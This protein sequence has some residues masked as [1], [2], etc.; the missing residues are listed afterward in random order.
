MADASAM[1]NFEFIIF[2]DFE[3]VNDLSL[4]GRWE[5]EA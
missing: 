1:N 2:I 4:V 5:H 3:F